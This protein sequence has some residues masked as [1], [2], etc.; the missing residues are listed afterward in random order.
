MVVALFVMLCP[1]FVYGAPQ[2]GAGKQSVTGCLQKGDES[3]GFTI[4]DKDGKVWELHSKTVKLGG[5][6]GHTVTVMGSATG[7]SKAEEAKIEA[8]EM[9]EAGGKEHAD[10]QVSGLKM[11][12]E[13][14]K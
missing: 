6:V 11:V 2:M 3:G 12:S 9:K 8:N 10:L 7:R 1:M 13:S 4:T 5:H 14:C